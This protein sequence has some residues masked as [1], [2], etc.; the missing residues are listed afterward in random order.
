MEYPSKSTKIRSN[1]MPSVFSVS[2]QDYEEGRAAANEW[3][4]QAIM[5]NLAHIIFGIAISQLGIVGTWYQRYMNFPE[6]HLRYIV[7]ICVLFII[8]GVYGMCVVMKR[9]GSLNTHRTAYIALSS[10]SL[11]ASSFI[12]ANGI[13]MILSDS[14]QTEENVIVIF[15]SL[16]L[17][18]AGLEIPSTLVGIYVTVHRQYEDVNEESGAEKTPNSKSPAS[19][20]AIFSIILNVAHI[21]LGLCIIE[22]G[23]VGMMY[24][25]IM[26]IDGTGLFAVVIVSISFI[27]VG[28]MGIYNQLTSNTSSLCSISMYTCASLLAVG[29]ATTIVSF[30]SIAM[31]S[32]HYY[33]GSEAIVAFDVMIL[34]MSGMELVV[35]LVA[36][37]LCIIPLCVAKIRQ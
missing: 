31:S 23:M 35:G 5:T 20:T 17:T 26:N 19:W 13:R 8:L 21:V 33:S 3:K 4:I 34:S 12:I 29:C 15:D 9:L 25:N 30:V 18:L 11:V 2:E 28:I 16:M 7:F 27:S 22:L 37:G 14:Y 10:F 32:E 36:T 6:D 24:R 1:S